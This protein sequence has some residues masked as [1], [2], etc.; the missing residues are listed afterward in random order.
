[1]LS[2]WLRQWAVQKK[3]ADAVQGRSWTG[4]L[5]QD[6]DRPCTLL[7][8]QHQYNCRTAA[9]VDKTFFHRGLPAAGTRSNLIRVSSNWSYYG[10]RFLAR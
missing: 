2:D 1:M 6:W 5:L 10:T 3:T 8:S 7:R 9:T 4:Q